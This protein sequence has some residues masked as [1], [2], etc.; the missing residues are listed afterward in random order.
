LHAGQ[1]AAEV[2]IA[3]EGLRRDLGGV[4]LLKKNEDSEISATVESRKPSAYLATTGAQSQLGQYPRLQLDRVML[5]EIATVGK[6]DIPDGN[7]LSREQFVEAHPTLQHRPEVS[8]GLAGAF[9]YILTVV[10]GLLE[11]VVAVHGARVD[12]C[13]NRRRATLLDF[14]CHGR[15][16][17]KL[18]SMGTPGKC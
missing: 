13:V 6:L 5:P 8:S 2:V 18:T 11:V 16:L 9:E 17:G 14:A 3:I 1:I 10:R 15:S 7:T 12:F 4:D